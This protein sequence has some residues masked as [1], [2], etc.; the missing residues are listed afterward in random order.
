MTTPII[1]LP[2]LEASQTQKYLTVNQVFR[3][4]DTL[5]NLTVFNRTT[6]APPSA[7]NEGDRYIVGPSP[8][9]IWA[10]KQNKIASFIGSAWKFFSA[11]EGWQCYDQGAN[12]MLLFMG[13]S[14]AVATS[15]GGG[16]SGSSE[17]T[18]KLGINAT[19]TDAKRL[20]CQSDYVLFSHDTSG[21]TRIT[22]NKADPGK[23]ASLIFQTGWTSTAQF[24]CL[25]D[26]KFTLKMGSTATAAIVAESSGAISFPQH[27]KF[28][29]FL[30]FG[31]NITAGSWATIPF[32]NQR[33]DEYAC[34]TLSSSSFLTPVAGFFI[35]SAG[36]VYETTG[37]GTPD[38]MRIGLSINGNDPTP[39]RTFS[40][41]D[42]HS[43]SSSI[44]IT[45]C[46]NLSA[47][48]TVSASVYFASNDGRI[49]KDENFFCGVQIA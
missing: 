12:T 11:S 7:P 25:G 34:F 2:E 33:H 23:D 37:S 18:E 47:G 3:E 26:D 29:A 31:Q 41:G 13:T 17:T 42:L 46:L 19:A 48:D 28:S 20:S 44:S 16:S 15:G 43:G 21:D 49:L 30:N 36:Y 9:G 32:N 35:F 27:R 6:S 24:G 45:S 10:G 1:G 22:V 38:K 40:V 5:V 39:D 8:T 14:W 4:L